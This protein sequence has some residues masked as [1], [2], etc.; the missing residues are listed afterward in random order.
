MMAA[1]TKARNSLPIKLALKV[2]KSKAT[3]Q[4]RNY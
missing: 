4:S 3:V 1:T 2:S